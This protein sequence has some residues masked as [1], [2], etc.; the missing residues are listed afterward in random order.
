MVLEHLRPAQIPIL[1]QFLVLLHLIQE[2]S[3]TKSNKNVRRANTNNWY[4]LCQ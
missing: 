4:S 2:K 3:Q 1:P